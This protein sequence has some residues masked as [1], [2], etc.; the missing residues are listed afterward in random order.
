[1]WSGRTSLS[2]HSLFVPILSEYPHAQPSPGKPLKRNEWRQRVVIISRSRVWYNKV[3]SVCVWAAWL[4][5]VCCR[6][7]CVN[8]N[9]VNG[10]VKKLTVKG[11]EKGAIDLHIRL[12]KLLAR[13]EMSALFD[14]YTRPYV[15]ICGNWESLLWTNGWWIGTRLIIMSGEQVKLD[16][17]QQ[18]QQNKIKMK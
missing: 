1:M 17:Q 13:K 2:S 5:C 7:I 14:C 9:M 18:Q 11:V 6:R 12:E 3:R 16:Q 4:L 15:L 8:P 10:P